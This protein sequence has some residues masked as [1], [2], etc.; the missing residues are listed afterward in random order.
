MPDFKSDQ[1]L[2]YNVGVWGELGYAVP[3]FGDD[4][5]T[6]NQTIQYLTAVMGRNLS[7]VM[8]HPDADLRVPP[9]INTLTR[10][11]KLIVRARSILAGRAVPSGTPDFEAVHV[12]PGMVEHLIFP[13]PYFKVRSP[14]LKEYCGLLLNGLSEAMQHTENRKPYEISVNFSGLIGAYLQRIYRR[15]ATELFG[16]STADASKLDFT[17]T[18][19]MLAAYNPSAYFTSTELIDRVPPIENVATED[20][21][22]VL[23]DGIPASQLVG[24]AR[25]PSGAAADSGLAA[26]S[27]PVST[28]ASFAPPPGP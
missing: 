11:H 21:L 2:W 12:Q 5:R 23:T 16:V 9:S 22:S 1:V 6:Q 4:P 8:H 25:Y 19:A 28:S 27:G 18:D 17:L 26:G 10:I 3:N 20:D 14:F 7:A 15:M 13:V 24:L